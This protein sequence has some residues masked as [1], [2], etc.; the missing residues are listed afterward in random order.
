M[1]NFNKERVLALVD[2]VELVSADGSGPF[3]WVYFIICVD[4]E[5]CKIG[6][7]KSDVDRRLKGLQTGSSSELIMLAKHPGT[8]DTE[9]KLHEMF[10]ANRIRGEWFEITDELRAYMIQTVWAMSEFSLKQ[11]RKLE[12]WMYVGVKFILD[13]LGTISEE[14]ADLLEAEPA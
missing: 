3:G 5:R 7:T 8:P 2:D 10:T 4:V 11:G 12:P 9:R 13:K 6:F 14:L 1:S